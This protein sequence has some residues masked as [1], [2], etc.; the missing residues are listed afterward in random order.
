M[1]NTLKSKSILLAGMLT[2]GGVTALADPSVAGSET[3]ASSSV[4]QQNQTV[5]GVVIDKK[6]RRTNHWSQR[7]CQRNN[8][9]SYYGF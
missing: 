7:A 9:W 2:L 8:Q 6:N 3:I 1:M 5:K 4:S